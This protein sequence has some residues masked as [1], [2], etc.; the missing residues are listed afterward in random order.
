MDS[1]LS[2][3]RD[4]GPA[5]PDHPRVDFDLIG[6]QPRQHRPLATSSKLLDELGQCQCEVS[7]QPP[8][9]CSYLDS[10]VGSHPGKVAMPAEMPRLIACL[11]LPIA[12]AAQRRI[13]W[14]H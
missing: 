6:T 8:E 11:S 9:R 4:S 2:G 7:H 10:D 14:H 13:D 1:A 3:A 5:A 12:L